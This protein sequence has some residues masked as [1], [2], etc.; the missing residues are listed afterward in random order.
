MTTQSG[1]PAE[2]QGTRRRRGLPSGC[3]LVLWI[4][5]LLVGILLLFLF[6][7][8][9]WQAV[10]APP[11]VAALI[12]VM[13]PTPTPTFTPA[14]APPTPK[15]EAI[16][17]TV[18][19]I[20]RY[21]GHP[22][23][24]N[25]LVR[26]VEARWRLPASA[27]PGALYLTNDAWDALD[28]YFTS[29][30]GDQADVYT[31]NNAE[32]MVQKLR[33]DPSG[34][35]VIAFDQLVPAL[36]PMKV[37]GKDIL[38][39]H[40]TLKQLD[41]YPFTHHRIEKN[42]WPHSNHEPSKFGVIWTTGAST[43]TGPWAQDPDLVVKGLKKLRSLFEG[44][45]WVHTQLD[46]PVFERCD[47]QRKE[48]LCT[49]PE[50]L[51]VLAQGRFNLVSI[52]SPRVARFGTGGALVTAHMLNARGMQAIG[53]GRLTPDTL[54]LDWQVGGR[55]IT[56]VSL[57]VPQK[58]EEQWA[59]SSVPGLLPYDPQNDRALL[60]A[61]AALARQRDSVVV[62]LR[63]AESRDLEKEAQVQAFQR[64]RDA[65]ADVVIG[66]QPGVIQRLNYGTSGLTAYGLGSFLEGERNQ[67]LALRLIFYDGRLI[68]A[69]PVFLKR[70]GRSWSM[71]GEAEKAHFWKQFVR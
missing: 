69:Q 68:A 1:F 39:P 46:V 36:Y 71:L 24:D 11:P 40:L 9:T 48:P 61:L 8:Q 10:H 19:A 14:P 15:A 17:Y 30:P 4:G 35:G 60:D 62:F 13:T 59:T 2:T 16:V 43:L 38:N 58:A 47:P 29:P 6:A 18:Y 12:D 64:L 51:D 63:W 45:N 3:A 28:D 65:G 49:S 21:V 67:T 32:E 56:L 22:G 34:W 5:L 52:A 42:T 23:P 27:S 31:V 26:D 44:G 55:T 70:T 66:V 33:K 7:P 53:L 37:D 41:D 50:M 57:G 25:I 54:G 20:V